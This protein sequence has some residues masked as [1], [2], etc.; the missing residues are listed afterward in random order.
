MTFAAVSILLLA[1]AL[2]ASYVPARRAI[3]LEPAVVLRN[4]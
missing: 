2:V 1:L 3:G 4:E